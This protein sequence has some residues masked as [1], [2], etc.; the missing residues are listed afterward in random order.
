MLSPTKHAHP[1]KT[2][3][4]VATLVLARLV[5]KRV[6]SYDKLLHMVRERIRGGHLLFI[7]ALNLLFLLG[8]IT[9]RSKTD[10]VEF[11]GKNETL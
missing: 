7:P 4:S 2:I 5:T 11:S 10:S 1:D 9:Y 3:L 6:E 8:L